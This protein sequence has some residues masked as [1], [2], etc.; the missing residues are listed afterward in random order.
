VQIIGGGLLP[1]MGGH[2]SAHAQ[3]TSLLQE[4]Q[5]LSESQ[6]AQLSESK[7]A[8]SYVKPMFQ[9]LGWGITS[10]PNETQGG[11]ASTDFQLTYED[12]VIPVDVRKPTGSDSRLKPPKGLE[13][14][15]WAIG[16]DFETVRIWDLSGPRPSLYL[17]SGPE[18]YLSGEDE[19]HDLLAAQV[20]YDRLVSQDGQTTSD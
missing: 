12:L 18:Q 14:V 19:Q 16:T 8:E 6:Q 11:A 10:G 9:A 5:D 2:R 15:D 20:F 1:Q 3:I 13:D 7:L 17:D 4:Y